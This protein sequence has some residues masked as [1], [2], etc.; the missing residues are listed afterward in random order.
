MPA[1]LLQCAFQSNEVTGLV[2]ILAVAVHSWRM[3]VF[4]VISVIL[5]TLVAQLLGGDRTLLGLGLFGFN[6]GLMG[7]ALG[8][9][10]VADTALWIAPRFRPEPAPSEPE[11]PAPVPVPVPAVGDA[12]S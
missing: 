4:Y 6:S 8:N 1:R 2:F 5:G 9:F 7:L 11:A 3:A 12:P 10:F